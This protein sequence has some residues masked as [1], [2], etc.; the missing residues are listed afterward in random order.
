M[1]INSK[2]S[3]CIRSGKNYNN[4][5]VQTCIDGVLLPWSSYLKYLGVTLK[6]SV[7]FTVDFK[8]SRSGF[9][10]S[11]NAIYSKVSRAKGDVILSLIKTFCMP[12]LLYGIEALNLNVSTLSNLDSP[13]RQAFY[14]VFKTFDKVTINYCMFYTSVLPP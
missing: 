2:K 12:T 7:K 10:K 9:Y 6:S 13:L 3:S 5:S 14:K 4:E 11:F 8:H 1:K